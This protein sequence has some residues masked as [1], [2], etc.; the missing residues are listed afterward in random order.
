MKGKTTVIPAGEGRINIYNGF[1]C[2]VIVRSS[3]LNVDHIGSLE[4][5]SVNYRPVAREDNVKISLYIDR[6]S[7]SFISKNVELNTTLTIIKGKVIF[8]YL[9]ILSHQLYISNI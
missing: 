1:D 7:C 6:A 4:M 3:S 5:I 2:N 9:N 8:I